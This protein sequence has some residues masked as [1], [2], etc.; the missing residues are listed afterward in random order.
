MV[1]RHKVA[2][3]TGMLTHSVEC[4]RTRVCARHSC[5]VFNQRI[6]P[7]E[8]VNI[9]SIDEVDEADPLAKGGMQGISLSC[10]DM[11]DRLGIRSGHGETKAVKKE[12]DGVSSQRGKNET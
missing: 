2:V 7:V 3:N 4:A 8:D 12:S 9:V 11:G 6:C 5:Q 1:L 10:D